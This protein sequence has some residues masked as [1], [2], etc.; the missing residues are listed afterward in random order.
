MTKSTP[1][2]IS[3]T[4][5]NHLLITSLTSHTVMGLY[6]KKVNLFTS[7]EVKALIQGGSAI[8]GGFVSM[9]VDWYML[10]SV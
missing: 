10:L 2:C 9:T 6:P 4:S 8:V 1:T 5:G 3:A 7:L